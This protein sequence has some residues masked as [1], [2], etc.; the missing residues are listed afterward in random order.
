MNRKF[1]SKNI[2]SR[3][4][5]SGEL[6]YNVETMKLLVNGTTSTIQTPGILYVNAIGDGAIDNPYNTIQYRVQLMQ[7]RITRLFI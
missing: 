6:V 4:P 1:L 7:Q 5:N 2:G 3:L